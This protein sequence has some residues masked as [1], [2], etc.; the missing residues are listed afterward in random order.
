MTGICFKKKEDSFEYYVGLRKVSDAGKA[1]TI[2]CGLPIRIVEN[3]GSFTFEEYANLLDVL[4][5][6]RGTKTPTVLPYPFK[7]LNEYIKIED[8]KKRMAKI[9]AEHT[10]IT[11]FSDVET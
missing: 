3:D 9:N 2:R 1:K 5:V 6:R 7:I 11:L 10:E 8:N 4:W